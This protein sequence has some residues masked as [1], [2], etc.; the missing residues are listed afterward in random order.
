MDKEEWFSTPIYYNEH[1]NVTG[2]DVK[3]KTMMKI[4]NIKRSNR[5]GWHSEPFENDDG[6][7]ELKKDI[8]REAN[9]IWKDYFPDATGKFVINSMWAIVNKKGDYNTIHSHPGGMLSGC[10][11]IKSNDKSGKI[12]FEDPLSNHKMMEYLF[13][14]SN[15]YH[16]WRTV[17]YEPV[18]GRCIFFPSFL[19]HEVLPN[20]SDEDRIVIAFNMVPIFD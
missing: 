15:T 17:S 13:T 9:D 10:I 19:K 12:Q 4:N 14:K 2:Y 20:E 3:V 16:T 8:E 18:Q 1:I 7:K 5:G 11:Y 6:F